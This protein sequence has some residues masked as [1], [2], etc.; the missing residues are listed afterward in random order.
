MKRNI[1]GEQLGSVR[2]Y[3]INQGRDKKMKINEKGVWREGMII[4]HI[5]G[6]KIKSL[7]AGCSKFMYVYSIM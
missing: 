3:K 7:N 6:I 2:L 5:E 4:F 1:F